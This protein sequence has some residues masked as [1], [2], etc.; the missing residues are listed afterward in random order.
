MNKTKTNSARSS[1]V[2]WHHGDSHTWKGRSRGGMGTLEAPKFEPA[3]LSEL[4]LRLVDGLTSGAVTVKVE[5]VRCPLPKFI[6]ADPLHTAGNGV[7]GATGIF[8]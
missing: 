3:C 2:S 6:P 4:M 5:W 1:L 8:E 7:L